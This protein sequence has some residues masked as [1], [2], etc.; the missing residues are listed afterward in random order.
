MHIYN[1][2]HQ[3]QIPQSGV[4]IQEVED[5]IVIID[6]SE[7]EN[8]TKPKGVSVI[9]VQDLDINIEHH[10]SAKI[11]IGS[12]CNTGQKLLDPKV[13]ACPGT[14]YKSDNGSCIYIQ[15]YRL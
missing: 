12:K 4:N 11:A 8:D 5:D 9:G 14:G 1:R 7:D 3:L 10:G 15:Y 13:T 6:Y 2:K